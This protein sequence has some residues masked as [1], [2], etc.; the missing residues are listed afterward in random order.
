MLVAC[1]QADEETAETSKSGINEAE[2][3]A[4]EKKDEE[5]KARYRAEKEAL[6]AQRRE[7]KRVLLASAD[8]MVEGYYYDEAIALLTSSIFSDD[9]AVTDKI[10]SIEKIKKELV[11]YQG[12]TYHVFFH[13]LIIDTDKAFDSEG[14]SA[15]G[16][17]LWMTTQSEFKKMLPLLLEEGYVL[18]SINDMVQ[19]NQDG[20]AEPKPI[21]LPPGKKPL[22]LSIDDVS[23]YDYM[24]NDGF[25]NRLLVNEQGDVVTEVKQPDG[26]YKQTYDGDVMPIVDQFVKEHPSF[27]YR[28][29]KGIVAP[30]GYQG[31][32]GYRITDLEDYSAEEVKQME[33]DAR[34]VAKRLR[35]TGWEMASHSYTHN[36]Y[37]RDGSI[38]LKQLKSEVGR[39]K[40]RVTPYIG[41]TNIFIS[42][43]GMHLRKGDPR[44]AYLVS[45]GFN[46]YCPVGANMRT[47]YI[48]G[49][50]IQE[51][52]NLDGLT[53]VKAPQNT[54][55]FFKAEEVLDPA[56]PPMQ[57]W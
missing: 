53:L 4:K 47:K 32:F 1:G 21:Y 15:L 44:L 31:I 33:A 14:H 5:E 13:S 50:M 8:F 17:N 54:K 51:R 39:W 24:L 23:Y 49:A 20:I 29:A 56:R 37:F 6:E 55:M 57:A 48:D 11:L 3:L 36:G 9:V 22:V 27:S 38:S 41:E 34:A 26:S 52:L 40:T 25:A 45:E 18:Y 12:P 16:Y 42:P 28:G 7:N 2:H 30:T 35:A 10:E 19:F 43:F 46:V